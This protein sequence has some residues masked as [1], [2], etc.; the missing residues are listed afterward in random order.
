[1]AHTFLSIHRL[2]FIIPHIRIIT[3]LHSI[4]IALEFFCQSISLHFVEMKSDQP[5]YTLHNLIIGHKENAVFKDEVVMV[6]I[7]YFITVWDIF[8]V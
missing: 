8:E 6:I 7:Y 3:N 1:M 2:K 5:S 4:S